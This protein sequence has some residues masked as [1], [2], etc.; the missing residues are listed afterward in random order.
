M[1][2]ACIVPQNEAGYDKAVTSIHKGTR[3]DVP[4]FRRSALV[5][6]VDFHQR[7]T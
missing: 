6:V 3:A 7:N 4:Q 1:A 5:Q 2:I